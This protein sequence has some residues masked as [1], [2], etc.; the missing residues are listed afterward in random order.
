MADMQPLELT[1]IAA[2]TRTMG[3][4]AHGSMPWSGLRREMQYFARVTSRLPPR[5]SSPPPAPPPPPPWP[6]D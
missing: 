2:A 4:G 1:L 3:I 5:V 6:R